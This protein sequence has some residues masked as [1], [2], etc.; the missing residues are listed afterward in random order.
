M[1]YRKNLE[2]TSRVRNENTG[3]HGKGRKYVEKKETEEM[4]KETQ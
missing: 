1:R 4:Y 3:K 2:K